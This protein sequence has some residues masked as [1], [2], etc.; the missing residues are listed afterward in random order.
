[1]RQRWAWRGVLP[2]SIARGWAQ[3]L[4]EVVEVKGGGLVVETPPAN[5]QAHRRVEVVRVVRPLADAMALGVFNR[6]GSR[7]VALTPWIAVYAA[8]VLPGHDQ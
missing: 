7:K 8:N 6:C 4:V 5:M 1:M 2:H 3:D